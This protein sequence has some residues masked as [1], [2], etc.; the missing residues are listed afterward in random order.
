MIKKVEYHE[1]V[2]KGEL[3][4][5]MEQRNDMPKTVEKVK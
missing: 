5:Q 2:L 3:C 1:K 4:K